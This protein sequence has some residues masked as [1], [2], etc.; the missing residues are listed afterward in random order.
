MSSRVLCIAELDH[1]EE[2]AEELERLANTGV[3]LSFSDDAE[4]ALEEIGTLAPDVIIVG[5]EVGTVEGL[6]FLAMA[7]ARYQEQDLPIVVLPRKGDPFPPVCHRRD[8]ASGRSTA[9]EITFDDLAAMV[10]TPSGLAPAA[11]VAPESAPETSDATQPSVPADQGPDLRSEAAPK[12]EG[13]STQDL[14][15]D[16]GRDPVETLWTEATPGATPP[17]PVVGARP[18]WLLP[19]IGV[20]L[21]AA[22]GVVAL[23]FVVADDTDQDRTTPASKREAAQV[24]PSASETSR[25]ER[26]TLQGTATPEG[27]TPTEPRTKV[28]AQTEPE[29]APREETADR[30]APAAPALAE[31]LVLPLRFAKASA[32]PRVG[33][34]K[35][36]VRLV[37]LLEDNPALHVIVGGHTSTE[38]SPAYNT[39]LGAQRARAAKRELTRRGI[40]PDRITVKSYGGSEPIASNETREGRA[41]NRRVTLQAK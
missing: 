31:P 38:G 35:R 29:V 19:A 2:Y 26:T 25:P 8:Q 37:R 6:E 5:M 24:E 18:R 28:E 4:A 17:A 41:R 34:E 40:A 21:A 15:H 12:P 23:L 7:L 1:R 3:E 39:D 13:L 20:G 22:I 33:D 11:A 9:D 30:P 36:L 14:P 16:P 27:E 32:E 10:S